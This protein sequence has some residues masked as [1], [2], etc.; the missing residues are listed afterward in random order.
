MNEFP[1]R[2]VVAS[3]VRTAIGSFGGAFKDIE[4]LELG[5]ASIREALGRCDVIGGGMGIAMLFERPP[6]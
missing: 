1:N 2:V 5:A 4:A 3:A 6:E